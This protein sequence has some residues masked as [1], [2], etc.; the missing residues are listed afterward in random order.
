MDE[1]KATWKGEKQE[2]EESLLLI[3]PPIESKVSENKRD[4]TRCISEFPGQYGPHVQ[5]LDM[6]AKLVDEFDAPPGFQI[7][8]YIRFNY[9]Q[10]ERFC[11]N[12][13]TKGDKWVCQAEG[14]G[15][16]ILTY[17]S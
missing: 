7:D 4:F 12:K 13:M 3:L 15:Q 6:S 1:V 10:C 11:M 16:F 17:N 2:T 5:L 14:L 9:S 8:N